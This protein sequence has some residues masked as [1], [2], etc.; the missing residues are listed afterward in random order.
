M[1]IGDRERSKEYAERLMAVG[2]LTGDRGFCE[3]YGTV[4]ARIVRFL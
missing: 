2:K 3:L 1:N 4:S